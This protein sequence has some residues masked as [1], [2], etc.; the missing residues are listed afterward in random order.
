[1]VCIGSVGVVLVFVLWC[2]VPRLSYI[3]RSVCE[4][5]IALEAY[6]WRLRWC[7]L[8]VLC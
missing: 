7:L 2:I 4:D 6:K 5:K 3:I 1:M 8:L